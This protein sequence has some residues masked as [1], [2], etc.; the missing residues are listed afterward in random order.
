MNDSLTLV[1][2]EICGERELYY[3][4]WESSP[5]DYVLIEDGGDYTEAYVITTAVVQKGSEIAD[6]INQLYN[7][8][9]KPVLV[10]LSKKKLGLESLCS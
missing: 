7:K 3:D 6:L 2:V 1:V 4:I 9:L 10:N 8:P 5:G